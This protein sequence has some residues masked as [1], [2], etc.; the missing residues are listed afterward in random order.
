MDPRH[1]IKKKKKRNLVSNGTQVFNHL[2]LTLYTPEW[3]SIDI[4]TSLFT[5]TWGLGRK[6]GR[7]IPSFNQGSPEK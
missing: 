3:G 5:H 4:L 7:V 6:M 2:I 1:R